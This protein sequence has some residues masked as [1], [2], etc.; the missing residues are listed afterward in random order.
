MKIGSEGK[1]DVEVAGPASSAMLQAIVKAK[2][3]NA[4]VLSTCA[5]KTVELEFNFHLVGE[6]GETFRRKTV[7]RAP[8]IFDIY[9]EQPEPIGP[10]VLYKRQR[11]S[12]TGYRIPSA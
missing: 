12:V 4:K 5:G 8:N 3:Q 1:F 2:L 11:S 9:S 10:L 6:P 7:F